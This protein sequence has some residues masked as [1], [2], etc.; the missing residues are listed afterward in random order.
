MAHYSILITSPPIEDAGIHTAQQF[1]RA[2]PAQGH[3]LDNVFFY[4][5]GV[6]NANALSQ[7]A[8][9]ETFPYQRWQLVQSETECRLIVC[10]TAALKRGIVGEAEALENGDSQYNLKAPFEQAGL[11]EFFSAIHNCNHLVQF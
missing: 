2:L 9:D 5:A 6:L 11:G 3:V 7:P 1:A 10:I 4:G 8:S